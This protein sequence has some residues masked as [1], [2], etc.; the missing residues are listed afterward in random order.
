M[1]LL[2]NL[3]NNSLLNNSFKLYFLK[4]SFCTHWEIKQADSSPHIICGGRRGPEE[5]LWT[6]VREA[7]SLRPSPREGARNK[8]QDLTSHPPVSCWGLSQLAQTN[9]KPEGKDTNTSSPLRS[10]SRAEGRMEDREGISWWGKGVDRDTV[11]VPRC[12]LAFWGN[13]QIDHHKAV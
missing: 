13:R 3:S 11:C 6:S 10:A 2:F 12:V 5:R 4:V 7:A 1:L 8:H 9:R